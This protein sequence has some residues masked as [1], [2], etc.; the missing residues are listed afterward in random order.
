MEATTDNTTVNEAKG[1]DLTLGSVVLW[2]NWNG[3]KKLSTVTKLAL[4]NDDVEV[5]GT[6]G[7][8]ECLVGARHTWLVVS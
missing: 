3:E 6:N 2:T 5:S 1:T 4:L 8:N 7:L